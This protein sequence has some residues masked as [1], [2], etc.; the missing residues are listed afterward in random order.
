MTNTTMLNIV[1]VYAEREG[2][3]N[4]ETGASRIGVQVD[5][6]VAMVYAAMWK[7]A[8]G[9]GPNAMDYD[10]L[11]L[12]DGQ[13]AWGAGKMVAALPGTNPWDDRS[14]TRALI[15]PTDVHPHVAALVVAGYKPEHCRSMRPAALVNGA[16]YFAV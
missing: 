3:H 6:Y 10:Y 13:G 7:P 11:V 2:F 5:P 1:F 9:I 16:V 14:V 12:V 15:D 4:D 8:T